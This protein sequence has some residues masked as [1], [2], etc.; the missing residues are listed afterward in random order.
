MARLRHPPSAASA[1]HPGKGPGRSAISYDEDDDIH[2]NGD[3][4]SRRKKKRRLPFCSGDGGGTVVIITTCGLCAVLLP[5][6]FSSA[7]HDTSSSSSEAH[8]ARDLQQ[9]PSIAA[10]AAAATPA[11][12]TTDA[13]RSA[14]CQSMKSVL[15]IQTCHPETSVRPLGPNCSDI[16]NWD[17]VQRCLTGRFTAFHQTSLNGTTNDTTPPPPI[18]EIHILGE[19]N[20]GTKFVTAELQ[21][22]FP[23]GPN[24]RVH[25][26]FVREKHWFQPINADD[27]HRHRLIVVVVRDPV[28]WMAAMRQSPYHSPAHVAGFDTQ[29]E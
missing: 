21:Q 2:N 7:Y 26:D 24:L 25:R 1:P 12:A 23:R 3:A 28:E 18:S 17:D 5:F 22:C 9:Q 29:D 15:D 8:Y 16:R 4:T 10:A 11:A 6:L 13:K 19:R 14:A 27:D 20:S